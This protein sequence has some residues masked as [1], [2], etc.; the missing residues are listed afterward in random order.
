VKKCLYAQFSEFFE[1]LE[2]NYSN[3][4]G[5]LEELIET[6]PVEKEQSKKQLEERLTS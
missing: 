1:E 3:L 2:I 4:E 6:T 5:E